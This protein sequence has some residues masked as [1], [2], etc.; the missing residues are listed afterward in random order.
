MKK[1][2]MI[3]F[4]AI[5]FASCSNHDFE[6]YSPDQIVKAEYDAKFIAEFGQPGAQQ[7]WG[8][9]ATTRAAAPIAFTRSVPGITFPT[10]SDGDCPS[11]PTIYSN[12]VPGGAIYAKTYAEEHPHDK[13]PEGAT[14]YID[15]SY[16]QF[17]GE[18]QVGNVKNL[19]IY[20]DGNITLNEAFNQDDKGTTLC[21]TENSI[22]KLK[23]VREN[24]T[25]YLAPKAQLDLSESEVYVWNSETN[26]G[27]TVNGAVF[28][29]STAALYMNSGS[30]VS[31]GALFFK[32]GYTVLN[33]A[34]TIN[35]GELH[36]ENGAVLYNK[37]EITA[38]GVIALRNTNGEIDNFGV[39]SGNALTM[40]ANAKFYN[41]AGGEVTIEGSTKINNDSGTNFWQNSGQYQTGSFEITGGC[42]DPAAFNNC[43]MI[44][45]GEF[46]MNHGNFVLDG[47]AAVEA[48]SFKWESDNYFHMGSKA[49]LKVTG[50][51]LMHNINSSPKY[52]FWGDGSEYAV[53]QAGSIQKKDA[54]KYRAAYYGNLFIDTNNH[55]TQGE[56]SADGTFYY[57]DETVKFSFTDNT[58]ISGLTSSPART[59]QKATDFSI[60]IPADQEN[61]CTPG[62]SYVPS[63]PVS[64]DGRIMA[65][66]LSVNESSDWDFNDVV[67]DYKINADGTASILLQ[68]A[69]GTLP[70][71][72]GGSLSGDE[73][74]LDESGNPKDAVEVHRD[75]FKV[76]TSTMVN[77]GVGQTKPAVPYTLRDKAYSS[78]ADIVLCVQKSVNGEKKWVVIPARKGD[79]AG[80]FVAEKDTPWCDEYANIKFAW[81]NF[82]NYVQTGSGKFNGE[83][84]NE[85]YFDRALKNERVANE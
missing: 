13:Y 41:V 29:K 47:G 62:Y 21:V 38:T 76:S 17:G 22:L 23:N 85:L 53:I 24:L 50:Q 10:F 73:V 68:A 78:P 31:G 6:T 39:M 20:V 72:I 57:F 37:N 52:G 1:Y 11:M 80:K 46:F 15:E 55:F 63:N 59:A 74:V 30:T 27:G 66:D 75:L 70:L 56:T 79:P 48:A 42:Q 81:G 16:P 18:N 83:S 36:V 4:A 19:T 3:G 5:A 12:T 54:G 28:T 2:L 44:V 69:G 84:K 60:T 51:M 49:L 58:D 40:D 67:I 14:L 34:G 45:D 65:E 8:F 9:G 35:V 61:G 77:T 7:D 82:T 26:T 64:F 43:H 32:D 33:E 71:T 25:I